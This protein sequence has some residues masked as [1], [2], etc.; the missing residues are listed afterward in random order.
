M[1]GTRPAHYGLR[2]YAMAGAILI[3]ATSTTSIST[4]G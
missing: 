2:W 1:T 3:S 4:S